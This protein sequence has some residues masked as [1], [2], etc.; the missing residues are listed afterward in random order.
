MS[1]ALT[2][3]TLALGI[4]RQTYFLGSGGTGPYVYSIVSGG[5]AI[6]ASSGLFTAPLV[7][8]VT[9]VR[10]TDSLLAVANLTLITGNAL[11][12]FCEVIQHEMD[13]LNGQVYLWDQK[14]N[15]PT[16]SKMYI[17]VAVLSAK[18]FANTNSLQ[19]DGSQ[20]LS[21]N[22]QVTLSVDILSRGPE[23]RDRKEEIILA[24]DSYYARAQQDT[25][26]FYIGKLSS[27]FVNLSEIDG[28]AIPYR[29]NISVN[30]QYTVIKARTQPYYDSFE[31]VEITEE[32]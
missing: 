22:M 19:A 11:E 27:S 16:D 10:V 25:N 18:P 24:L 28:A 9:V 13:L 3:G 31:D 1:I 23:A 26:G 17:A 14:I 6:G 8:G 7:T 20:L 32:A 5:G 4:G 15:I 2:A 30:L 29:F 12:L 21:A